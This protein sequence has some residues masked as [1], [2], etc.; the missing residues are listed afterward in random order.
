MIIAQAGLPWLPSIALQINRAVRLEVYAFPLE[1][2]ALRQRCCLSVTARADLSVGIDDAV[3]GQAIVPGK[4]MQ[5]VAHQTRV[6]RHAGQARNLAVGRHASP[7]YLGND[8][9]NQLIGFGRHHHRK[10]APRSCRAG[11]GGTGIARL[12]ILLGH[13][14][15]E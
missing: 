14:T 8:S 15:A 2:A 4:R 9:V 7:W 3:P 12:E 10:T 11:D 5:G 1:L 13:G 6:P